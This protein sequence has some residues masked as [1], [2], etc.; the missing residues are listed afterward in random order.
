MLCV[1]SIKRK[2]ELKEREM[3]GQSTFIQRQIDIHS[4]ELIV[5]TLKASSIVYDS[6]L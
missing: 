1:G 6:R 3:E 4:V 2:T 5:V